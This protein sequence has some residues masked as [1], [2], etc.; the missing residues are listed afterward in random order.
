LSKAGFTPRS[1]QT[2]A[3]VHLNKVGEGFGITGIDLATRCEVPGV[4]EAEFQ[5]LAADAK[6]NCII[7]KALAVPIQFEASLITAAA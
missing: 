2:T 4:S 3:T 5:R 1:I 7:S 6:A